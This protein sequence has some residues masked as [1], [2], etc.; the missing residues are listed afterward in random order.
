MSTLKAGEDDSQC[1]EFSVLLPTHNRADVLP[2]AVRSVLSQTCQD[3]ELLLVGDGCTDETADVVR[4]F[5]DARIRWFDLPKAPHFGYANRNVALREVAGQYVAHMTH[6][7]LWLPD[8]LELL[9]ACLENHGAEIAYSRWVWAGPTGTL[10]P[11]YYNLNDPRVL[12][13]FLRRIGVGWAWGGCMPSTSVLHRR[14]CLDKYGY[15]DEALPAAA[16]WDLWARIIQGGGG[17]NFAYLPVPTCL[18]FRA[19]WRSES[20]TLPPAWKSQGSF[21]PPL[22]AVQTVRVPGGVT[23]QGA[24]WAVLSADPARWTRDLRTAVFLALD[25][26]AARSEQITLRTIHCLRTLKGRAAPPGTWRER[27]LLRLLGGS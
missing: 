8:H 20:S 17:G 19:N 25:D 14:Q 18:H 2:L 22:P 27:L 5:G 12:A 6:D 7:D 24:V 10:L 26:H 16:D 11:S 3:F 4:G 9:S 21:W 13:A 23:A 1:P 15:M